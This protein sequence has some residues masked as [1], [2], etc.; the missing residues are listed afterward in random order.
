MSAVQPLY[1]LL[2]IDPQ[3]FFKEELLLLEAELFTRL[4]EEIKEIIRV[5]NA[6]YFQVI[7][8]TKE[9]IMLESK[10]IHFIVNDILFTKEYTTAGI[11]LYADAPEDVIYDLASG[12]NDNPTFL[13][14]RK[15]IELHRMVRPSL[16]QKIANKIKQELLAVV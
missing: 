10:L 5:E 2:G 3:R 16:Y 6:N 15:I 1:L 14:S 8:L 9:R 7:K 13:L 4:F 12:C 11:A